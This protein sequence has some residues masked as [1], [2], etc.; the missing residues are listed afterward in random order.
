MRVVG[1]SLA[2]LAMAAVP[3]MAAPGDQWILGINHIDKQGEQPFTTYIGAGYS[4]PQSNGDSQY[5]GNAY[6]FASSGAVGVNRVYWELKG[7]AV[8]SGRAVPT[9]AELYSLEFYGTTE[10][11]HNNWQPVESQYHGI[12]GEGYPHEPDIPWIGQS[13]TNHQYLASTGRD[14]GAWHPIDNDGQ[15]GPQGPDDASFNAYGDGIYMWLTSGSWL[16]AKW[17]F[18]FPIDRS[19]SRSATNANHR[20]GSA[21]PQRRFQCRR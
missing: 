6:G 12:V 20:C 18:P 1:L 17:D 9:T 7:N 11:G 21:G 19:W 14:D 4:G 5:V 3:A 13:G 15:G 8:N 10:A 16:Y 2:I